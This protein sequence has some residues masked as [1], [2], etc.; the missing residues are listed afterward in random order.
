M[1]NEENTLRQPFYAT[2]SASVSLGNDR[3]NL[4]LWGENITGTKYCTFYFKSIGN[5]FV[6]RAR[7]WTIGA[8]LRINF[9]T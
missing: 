8:T 5:E 3:W 1:W 7:P 4:R 6:Q 2:L 9:P